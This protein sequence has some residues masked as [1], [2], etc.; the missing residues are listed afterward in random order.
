MYY[1]KALWITIKQSGV[2]LQ[3]ENKQNDEWAIDVDIEYKVLENVFLEN[4]TLGISEL[5]HKRSL[6]KVEYTY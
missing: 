4:Y 1:I 5:I 3:I 6:H 2:H